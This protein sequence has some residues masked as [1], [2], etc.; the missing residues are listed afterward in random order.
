M[1][2]A[3]ELGVVACPLCELVM[4]ATPE[5]ADCPRCGERLSRV[6]RRSLTRCW[7]LVIAAFALYFP[8]NVLPM[9]NTEQFPMHRSDTIISGIKFLWSEGS[10]ELAALVFAASI[11]VPL[12]KLFALGFLLVTSARRS[13]WRPRV[14]T[15]LYRA[16]EVIGHWSM[17][18]VFVVSLLTAV[19]QLGR[20][21]SVEPGP[22]VLPFASV[23]VLTM[24]ASASFDPRTI[25]AGQDGKSA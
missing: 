20:F 3:K 24:L 15:K 14:R 22:A 8:A 25:W 9:M 12:T 19:V 21:A 17:L 13:T 6:S 1:R 16:L 7:A 2:T 5:D 4:R 10:W 23:V 18:D 11:L